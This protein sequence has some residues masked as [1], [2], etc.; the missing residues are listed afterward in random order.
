MCGALEYYLN[1]KANEILGLKVQLEVLKEVVKEVVSRVENITTPT[2]TGTK[3]RR[4]V[5]QTLTPSPTP[6]S[7]AD[8][9]HVEEELGNQ[10]L[11]DHETDLSEM[12]ITDEEIIAMYDTGQE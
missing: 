12:E 3:K 2:K 11:P 8:L 10:Y 1:E 9:D 7:N 5:K 6:K 4:R